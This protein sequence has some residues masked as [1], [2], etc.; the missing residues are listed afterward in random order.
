MGRLKGLLAKG[1]DRVMKLILTKMI[2][3][4]LC[5]SL[6]SCYFFRKRDTGGEET[7]GL[8]VDSIGNRAGGLDREALDRVHAIATDY[9][10]AALR[11]DPDLVV[12]QLLLQYRDEGSTVA[13]QIGE[14]ES[15]RLLLGGANEDFSVAPQE[16]YDATSLLANLKVAEEICEG[17]V[18]PTAREHPGWESILP[19]VPSDTSTNLA[20]LA[21][22]ILG[23]PLSHVGDDV[24]GSLDSILNTALDNGQITERS[25]IPVCATLV[26]DARALLF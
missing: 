22:R 11:P 7:S 20:F 6:A 14:V 18:A 23:L 26:L 15:Y 24:I 17:L 3:F 21:Q 9:S 4:L 10:P 5:G 25:Y 8:A 19:A 1:L 2:L 12:R 13:R 16:S